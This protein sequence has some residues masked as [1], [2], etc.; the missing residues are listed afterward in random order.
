MSAI[1][2][3]IGL[4]YFPDGVPEEGRMPRRPG[5]GKGRPIDGVPRPGMPFPGR[6]R[7]KKP[8][9]GLPNPD[10]PRGGR[11]GWPGHMDP[12]GPKPPEVDEVD[13]FLSNAYLRNLDRQIDDEGK[14]YWGEEIRSGRASKD[15]VIG[16][17]RRSDEYGGVVEKFLSDAY[18]TN[19]GR[20]ADT[21]G[22]DYWANELKSGK[23]DRDQVYSAIKGSKEA[24]EYRKTK[25]PEDDWARPMP[26]DERTPI[27]DDQFD[28]PMPIGERIPFDPGDTDKGWAGQTPKPRIESPTGITAVKAAI[29]RDN[30]GRSDIDKQGLIKS[31]ALLGRV[32]GTSTSPERPIR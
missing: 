13:V 16:N 12:P 28:R 18:R 6:P 20:D 30:E 22:F 15:D 29:D 27:G 5:P 3:P 26:I 9:I 24:E 19:L 32:L 17:I 14:K 25:P 21:E 23:M 10:D 2:P 8:I 31:A 4:P 1:L 11:P 7:P